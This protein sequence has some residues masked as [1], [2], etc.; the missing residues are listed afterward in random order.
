MAIVFWL[1]RNITYAKSILTGSNIV[2]FIFFFFF[3]LF[4]Y[5][6]CVDETDGRIL[7]PLELKIFKKLFTFKTLQNQKPVDDM[8]NLLSIWDTVHQIPFK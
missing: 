7:F 3:S 5:S 2:I 1:N 8:K 6:Y 4:I